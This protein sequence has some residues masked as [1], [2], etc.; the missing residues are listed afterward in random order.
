MTMTIA[1]RRA[2][3]MVGTKLDAARTKNP[4]ANENE[5]ISTGLVSTLKTSLL[6]A[7]KD[8]QT[9]KTRTTL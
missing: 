7:M 5:V 4:R 2:K 3:W 1:E 8:W 9:G 6:Q